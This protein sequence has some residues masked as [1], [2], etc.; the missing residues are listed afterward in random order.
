M[1]TLKKLGLF[2][3]RLA[4]LLKN[5]RRGLVKPTLGYFY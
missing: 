2:S 4:K 5:L 3:T 1:R